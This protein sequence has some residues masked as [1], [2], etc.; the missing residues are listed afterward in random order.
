MTYGYE[1]GAWT[2]IPMH[3]DDASRT[4]TIGTRQGS[5]PGMLERRTFT[6][7]IVDPAHPRG[8]DPDA[9]GVEIVY[10]GAEIT[11]RA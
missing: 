11:C 7:V 8:F 9:D 10:D 4:L 3:W 2:A 5:F 6:V 1:K